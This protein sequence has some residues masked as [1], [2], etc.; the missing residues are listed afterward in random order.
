MDVNWAGLWD[1]LAWVAGGTGAGFLAYWVMNKLPWKEAQAELKRYSGLALSVVFAWAAWF[2]LLWAGVQ[3]MP[4][5][6]KEW[7]E[8]L[9]AVAVP[10]LLASQSMHGARELRK[11]DR[12]YRAYGAAGADKDAC[13]GGGSCCGG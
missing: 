1:V 2:V 5:G 8:K 4:I 11:A 3:V 10:A 6:A 13:C 9:F 7:L 12:L